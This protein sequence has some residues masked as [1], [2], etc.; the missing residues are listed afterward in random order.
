MQRPDQLKALSQLPT[1]ILTLY[2]SMAASDASRHPLVQ[3][4]YAWL[5]DQAAVIAKSLKSPDAKRFARQAEHVQEFLKNRHPEEKALVIFAGVKTWKLL[6]LYVPVENELHWGTPQLG[7]LIRLRNDHE[8]YAVVVIDHQAVRFFAYA[9]TELTQLAENNFE[10]DASQWKKKGVG[11]FTSERSQKTRGA[12]HDRFEHRVDAQYDRLC[13]E[14]ADQTVTLCKQHGLARTFIVGPDRLIR[15]IQT[16]LPRPFS[17]SAILIAEDLGKSSPRE[18]LRYLVPALEDR[19]RQ[20]QVAEVTRLLSAE[21]G[22]VTDFDET[23]SRLQNGTTHTLFVVQGHD[24][25]LHQCVQCGV[26]NRSADPVCAA[27]GGQLK[28]VALRDVLPKLLV[29]HDVKIEF[30]SGEAAQMLARAGGMAGWVRQAK[31]TSAR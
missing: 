10:I 6:P 5:K 22:A 8:S 15:I 11:Q 23:L 14:T 21:H 27:C 26:V 18:L 9:P 30:V 31:A 12:D 4:S 3:S 29:A 28:R 7:Q 24:L 13:R 25:D 19:E 17:E 1:P 2:V 20:H 16:K